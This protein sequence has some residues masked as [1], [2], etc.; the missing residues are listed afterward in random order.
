MAARTIAGGALV[1]LLALGLAACSDSGLTGNQKQNISSFQA[2]GNAICAN[3][4]VQIQAALTQAK[5]TSATGSADAAK[6]FLVNVFIPIVE[7]E[8]GDLHN[9]GE[10][11]LNRTDWDEIRNQLDDALSTLKASTDRDP[12]SALQQLVAS[13]KGLSTSALDQKFAA[14][15][16]TECAKH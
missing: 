6:A 7:K 13:G 5:S 14:I 4:N 16:L 2:N 10:P 15:G 8:L 9:L 12:A 3:A 11:T 1:A